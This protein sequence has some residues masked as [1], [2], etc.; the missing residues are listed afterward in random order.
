M[1]LCL[2]DCINFGC[3][4]RGSHCEQKNYY[5][6]TNNTNSSGSGITHYQ[7]QVRTKTPIK[8]S[9][10][11]HRANLE[12]VLTKDLSSSSICVKVRE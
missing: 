7:Q 1:I 10:T 4:G 11:N 5:H 12:A 2:V 3:D 9:R 8:Q 6:I